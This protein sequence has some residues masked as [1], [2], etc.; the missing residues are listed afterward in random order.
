MW[1]KL[2]AIEDY[3]YILH[4]NEC[5]YRKLLGHH[6]PLIFHEKDNFLLIKLSTR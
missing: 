5:M 2:L 1:R 6:V 3:I 4:V